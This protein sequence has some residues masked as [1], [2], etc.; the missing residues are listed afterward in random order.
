MKTLLSFLPVLALSL[1]S[2]AS[3]APTFTKLHTFSSIIDKPDDSD[4]ANP[5]GSLVLWGNTLYGTTE[6]GGTGGDGTVF[7]VQIDGTGF[8]VL[9][10]F[11]A[12]YETTNS[13][14]ASPGA[15]LTLSGDTLYGSTQGGGAFGDGTLFAI[16]TDGTD[17]RVLH[18]FTEANFLG[19]NADGTGPWA[20]LT[21]SNDTL[22]GTTRYGG[23]GGQGVV[24]SVK[25]DGSG[26]TTLHSFEAMGLSSQNTG[27]SQPNG[28]LLLTNGVLYGTTS[29]GGPAG[30]GTLFAV[31]T[32]GTGYR[33]LH[34][35]SVTTSDGEN[36]DGAS[37]W[38]GMVLS[39]ETLYGSA[40][41]GGAA[42]GGVVFAVNTNG[43]D[44]NVVQNFSSHDSGGTGPHGD[45]VLLGSTLYGCAQGDGP[46]SY[47]TV[48]SVNTD[49]S[50]FKVLYGFST[51][52]AHYNNLDGSNPCGGLAYTNGV[53][54]GATE[55]GSTNNSGTLYSLKAGGATNSTSNPFAA[56]AGSYNGLFYP[57]N[58]ITE[59]SAGFLTATISGKSQGSYSGL[60]SL[61]GGRYSFSGAFDVSGNSL[62]SVKRP[63][64]TTVMLSLHLNVSAP[65]NLLS[66]SVSAAS[67]IAPLRA[68]RAVFNPATKPATIY[69]GK[70]TLLIPP[71]PDAPLSSPGGY[72]YAILSINSGGIT[73][74]SG[75]LPDGT[76]IGPLS[77]PIAHD[78]SV[79]LY[80]SLYAGKGSLLGWL[81]FSNQPPQTVTGWLNWI[82]PVSTAKTLYPAGFGNLVT[83]AGS[84]FS[85]G[86]LPLLA[87]TNATLTISNG[88]LAAPV[89]FTVSIEG[90]NIKKVGGSTNKLSASINPANGEMMVKFRPTGAKMD[91]VA[92]G[93]VLQNQTNAA[94]WFTGTSESGA[95][96]LQ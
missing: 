13:D 92:Q 32:D 94:G 11:T 2:F 35:F 50:G 3:S 80:V 22:Y 27:G 41:L 93:V 61:E 52:D 21:V 24:F 37:P 44:Y 58:E 74:F 57:T 17:F 66:G 51:V 71:A 68:D 77:V 15:S 76:A 5:N 23:S 40:Y 31:N 90:A 78:G 36:S 91:K 47:G 65:D 89:S 19:Y 34:S 72:G 26:F 39:G 60:L 16:G 56:V 83:I 20:E 14:G 85:A 4:G 28:A 82:K 42:D 10:Q 8:T 29:T 33:V 38:G 86:S 45:L 55:Q 7:S 1:A 6:L 95:F 88:N 73:L 48:F 67:W 46:S 75:T 79:P 43:T 63:G 70:F 54:Y 69:Q 87:S 30:N 64:K 81:D 9:H 59:Q 25:S 96:W 12:T 18:T 53:F 49:G 84:P 62:I